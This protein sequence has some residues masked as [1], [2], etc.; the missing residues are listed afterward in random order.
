MEE[1]SQLGKP[2]S[3][4]R[5]H[6]CLATVP[7]QRSQ[8]SWYLSSPTMMPHFSFSSSPDQMA[9][10]VL[11]NYIFSFSSGLPCLLF[12]RSDSGDPPGLQGHS[13]TGSGQMANVLVNYWVDLNGI[14]FDFLVFLEFQLA[15]FFFN[16]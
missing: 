11:L 5:E 3:P 2:D 1:S 15:F 8:G 7:S 13:G 10:V 16:G 14:F 9:G 6:V 4:L 12:D